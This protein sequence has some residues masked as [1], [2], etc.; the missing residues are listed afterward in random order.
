MNLRTRLSIIVIALEVQF[1][2]PVW[3]L[4]LLDRGF[5]VGQAALADGVFRLVATLAEV[6]AGWLSDRIGRKA[7]LGIALGGTA[8]TFLL[9]ASVSNMA[10]LLLAWS[11][12][13]VLWALVS[14]LLTA[15]AW[16]LG[17]EVE[18][19]GSIRATEFV[20]VRRV[21][22]A[23]AML[24]S[25]VTAGWL[26]ELAPTLPFI[27][28]AVLALAVIP[29]AMGLPAIPH[30][31]SGNAYSARAL[32]MGARAISPPQRLALGAGA[33]VLVAGWSIQMVFQPLGLQAGLD[34]T[35]ISFLFAGFALAQ[36]AGAWL[37]GRI[38]ARRETILVGSVAGIAAMCFGAWL[39]FTHATPVWVSI[40][41][42]VAL[43]VFYA[44]GTTY[45][46]I[47]VS[48]LA[49]TSNRATMLSLVALL[50]GAVMI[51]SRP[52]LG[53]VADATSAS[54]AFG[55]WAAV[56][57]LFGWVLWMMLRRGVPSAGAPGQSGS[58]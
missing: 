18:G 46:D 48:E 27:V 32:R 30:R 28:T 33:I 11:V 4:F 52:L 41:S 53:L 34:P 19:G 58:T 3:L 31:A 7:S 22:A 51:A 50:G 37:V 8:L 29:V 13:G 12:W 23:A 45:C 17:S 42:L 47:W 5:T 14:G 1:W 21:C 57:A 25:L 55:L 43:G 38:P 16:E 56:C 24:F 2:F 10:G 49:T 44:V 6:P 26:Y 15:Y 35:G 36:L 54:E 40:V 9:I 20:R 39:G